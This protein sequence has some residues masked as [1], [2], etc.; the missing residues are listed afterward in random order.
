MGQARNGTIEKARCGRTAFLEQLRSQRSNTAPT[1][2]Q[3]IDWLKG[4]L[5]SQRTAKIMAT[6]LR[7]DGLPMGRRK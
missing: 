2:E 4:E 3:V 6:I 5:V 1:N 7:A